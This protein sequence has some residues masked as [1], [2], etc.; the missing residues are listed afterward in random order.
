MYL[1][2]QSCHVTQ[3]PTNQYVK[4]NDIVVE[5]VQHMLYT[6]LTVSGKIEYHRAK[7]HGRAETGEVHGDFYNGIFLRG[8]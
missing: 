8:S 7:L 5:N 1:G 3:V 2:M 4:F 6:S